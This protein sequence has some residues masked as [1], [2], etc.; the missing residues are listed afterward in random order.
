[1]GF[2]GGSVIKNLLFNEGNMSL[3]PGFGRAPR[4]G[5][6]NP[7]QYSSLENPMNRGAWQG[8]MMSQRVGHDLATEQQQHFLLS[9]KY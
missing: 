6:D 3:I 1:M 8:S 7:L 2:S 5:N 4:G 9:E